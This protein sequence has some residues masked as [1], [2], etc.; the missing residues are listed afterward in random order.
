MKSR[1]TLPLALLCA[2]TFTIAAQAATNTGTPEMAKPKL[3]AIASA[4]TSYKIDEPLA[5]T[6]QFEGKQCVFNI[7]FKATDGTTKSQGYY[8]NDPN[9]LS[10]ALN[11]PASYWGIGAGSYTVSAVPHANAKVAGANAI[12]CTGGPVTASLKI[13]PPATINPAALLP[14]TKSGPDK[15]G[16]KQGAV[17]MFKPGEKQGG[18]IYM[19]PGETQGAPIFMKPGDKAAPDAGKNKNLPAGK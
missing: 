15:P 18:P 9:Q 3:K 10:L 2:A 7:E 8:F 14:P 6:V 4:K 16:E 13:D 5:L 1:S 17:D 19:K 11:G 12:A